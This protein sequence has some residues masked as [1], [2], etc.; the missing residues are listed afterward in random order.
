M[1]RV[2]SSII[3]I[4][5]PFLIAAVISWFIAALQL[6]RLDSYYRQIPEDAEQQG[7][8]EDW[9]KENHRNRYLVLIVPL[10]VI[11]IYALALW[12]TKYDLLDD[13]AR[14]K[15]EQEIMRESGSEESYD[16]GHSDGY[17][18]GYNDGHADGY[19]KG[20]SD[21]YSE[22]SDAWFDIGYDSGYKS[23]YDAG[24]SYM[25]DR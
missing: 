9:I 18:E 23:G 7:Y 15:E 4:G 10:M 5:L 17:D 21:G 8:P 16:Q 25:I 14:L 6:D 20:H 2:L 12:E 1:L 3:N 24:I 11:I 13:I 19:D 22:G